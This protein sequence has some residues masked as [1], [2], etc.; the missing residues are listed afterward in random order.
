MDI[1]ELITQGYNVQKKCQK[2]GAMGLEDYIVGEEYEKWIQLSIRFLEQNISDKSLVVDF[3]KASDRANGNG[4]KHFH[5]M[6]GILEA[7]KEIP[8]QITNERSIEWVLEKICNN[9]NKCAKGL[10]NRHKDK[11]ISRNT[12]EIKDEYDVQDLMFG[13]LKLFVDDI[14][15][16]DYVPAYAGANSRIDFHLPTYEL[17][18]ETKMTREN[19]KDKEVGEQLAIDIARYNGRCKTLVCFIYDS[20]NY[21]E[22]PYGLI[23]D[24]ENLSTEYLKIKVYVSPL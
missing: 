1:N 22:N 17:Y 5:T 7:I 4:V 10:L 14:R 16:E 20:G 18:V 6:I 23:T 19:L 13:I 8:P 2:H 9:F 15:P 11:G 21:L 3:K 24:L 12:I